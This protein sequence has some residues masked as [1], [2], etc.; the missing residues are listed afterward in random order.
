MLADSVLGA[1]FQRCGRMS[2]E[3]VNFCG[4]LTAAALAYAISGI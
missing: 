3:A 2:N 1:T 4:T